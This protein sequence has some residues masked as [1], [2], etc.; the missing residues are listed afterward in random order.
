M[1]VEIR[2]PA[3]KSGGLHSILAVPSIYAGF[4]LLMGAPNV[5]REFVRQLEVQPG[6]RILDIGCGPGNI[7][8]FLPQGVD[9]VGLDVSE[10]YIQQ[11]NRRYGG[12]GRFLCRDFNAESSLDEGCFDRV[13]AIG[14]LH[15]LPDSAA[16]HLFRV[17]RSV[18][19]PQGRALTID[20]CFTSQQSRFARMIVKQDRGQAVRTVEDYEL[21]A[22]PYFDLIRLHV[23]HNLL[24][25]PYTHL[26]IECSAA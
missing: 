20:P 23:R 5:W 4:Q 25:L 13:M 24:R 14:L 2:Q 10:P 11:A 18:L 8:D 6:Q 26:F 7:L 21:L 3:Q 12:R 15:H 22:R 19:K 17:A 16:S 9:Y 1:S